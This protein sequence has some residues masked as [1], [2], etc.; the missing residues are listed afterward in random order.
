MS[1]SLSNHLQAACDALARIEHL[2]CR[3]LHI[4][5]SPWHPRAVIQIADGAPLQDWLDTQQLPH[6][7]IA[8]PDDQVWMGRASLSDVD[9]LWVVQAKRNP[10]QSAPAAALPVERQWAGF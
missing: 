6:H 9:V 8:G 2:G 1:M 10:E 3:V 5:C 4:H 7:L